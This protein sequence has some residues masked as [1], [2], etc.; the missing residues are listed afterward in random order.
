MSLVR[1]GAEQLGNALRWTRPELP[2]LIRLLSIDAYQKIFSL[3][4]LI[5][6]C[7]I[8]PASPVDGEYGSS[9]VTT[10]DKSCDATHMFTKRIFVCTPKML[11]SFRY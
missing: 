1:Y 4:N 7:I 2:E 3:H 11:M 6:Y 8:N 5:S 10:G 9:K